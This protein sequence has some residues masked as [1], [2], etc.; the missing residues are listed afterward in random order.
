MSVA[1]LARGGFLSFQSSLNEILRALVEQISMSVAQLARGGFLSFQSSRNEILREVEFLS[2]ILASWG[3]DC[4]RVIA[5]FMLGFLGFI[6]MPFFMLIL[7]LILMGSKSSGTDLSSDQYSK[8]SYVPISYLQRSSSHCTR[9]LFYLAAAIRTLIQRIIWEMETSFKV[10]QQA[11]IRLRSCKFGLQ[12]I[13]R[14]ISLC[15]CIE[16]LM[17]FPHLH[18]ISLPM[19]SFGGRFLCPKLSAITNWYYA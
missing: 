2:D 13:L 15:A 7:L 10:C 3:I 18:W 14:Q 11:F 8:S 6:V 1:Q 4:P 16:S 5:I 9:S 19:D 12:H 17:L